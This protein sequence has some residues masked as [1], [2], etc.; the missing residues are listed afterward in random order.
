M[1]QY[2]FVHGK[3][4]MMQYN[5]VHGKE[6]MIQWQHTTEKPEP[7]SFWRGKKSHHFLVAKTWY[8]ANTTEKPEPCDLVFWTAKTLAT[9]NAHHLLWQKILPAR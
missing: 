6:S 2:N 3:E 5:F 9:D 4:N 7:M 8:S 1:M